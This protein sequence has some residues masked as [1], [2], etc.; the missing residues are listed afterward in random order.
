MLES[1]TL[2]PRNCRIN[3]N[4]KK[5]FCGATSQPKIALYSLHQ[6]EEPCISGK[7]GSGTIFFTG[8]HLRCQ[9]CQNYKV[10]QELNGDE[11]TVQQL[12][13]IFL[14]LQTR[15][16]HNINLVTGFA[17]VPH[18]IQAFKLAQ[19][20]GF[21]LP[22]VYN[23]SGYEKLETLQM[24]EGIVDIYLPDF[25]YS[26]NELGKQLSSVNNYYEVTTKALKEMKRQVGTNQFDDQGIMQKGMIVRHLIL[27]N[28]IQNSKKCLKWI[29]Q[30]LGRNTL[31]SIMAQYF[32]SHKANELPDLNRKLT[33][34]ELTQVVEYAKKIGLENGYIQDIEDEEEKYVPQF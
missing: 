19:K 22:I 9:F 3:R 11:I 27:P 17:Y 24:L 23:S 14:E 6:Y 12:C 7:Y 1:C 34:D 2:C 32:P 29:R 10:S 16:A 28:H 31:V 20:N 21:H 26:Y 15:Q 4:E 33:E 18:I 30:T 5:G 25:K 13:D 8:C